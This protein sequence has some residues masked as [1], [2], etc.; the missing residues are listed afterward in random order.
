MNERT[1]T[2]LQSIVQ[3]SISSDGTFNIFR[4]TWLSCCFFIWFDL[5]SCWLWMNSIHE[6][7]LNAKSWKIRMKS[8]INDPQS[9]SKTVRNNKRQP[10]ND[11][12][13][14]YDWT[15]SMLRRWIFNRCRYKLFWCESG[16]INAHRLCSRSNITVSLLFGNVL[17]KR[18]CV[19]CVPYHALS[20][21]SI[22][23]SNMLCKCVMITCAHTT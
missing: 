18:G 21:H 19:M 5:V 6:S 23:S 10:I 9:K 3:H 12:S 11:Q 20:I 8:L 1:S 16:D 14:N 15:V 4:R 17:V 22:C 7:A 2:I 13:C